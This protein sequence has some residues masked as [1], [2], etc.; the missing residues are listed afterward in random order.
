M[1]PQE[2]E[3]ASGGVGDPPPQEETAMM[4][5]TLWVLG[6]LKVIACGIWAHSASFFI[7]I[8]A[9]R[10]ENHSKDPTERGRERK[11]M[12]AAKNEKA[13]RRVPARAGGRPRNQRRCLEGV[14]GKRTLKGM[15]HPLAFFSA[16]LRSN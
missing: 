9:A 6:Q 12:P 3:G 8:G 13:P 16:D 15:F 4:L 14:S 5:G 11:T 1:F 7:P 2:D 10:E